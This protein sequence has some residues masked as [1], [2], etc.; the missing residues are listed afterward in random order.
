MMVMMVVM[1]VRTRSN[2]DISA[3]TMMVMMMA[4]HNLGGPDGG[5][6]GQP[7]VVGL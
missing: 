3:R 7:R 5:G 2:P 6:L 4:D 1:T